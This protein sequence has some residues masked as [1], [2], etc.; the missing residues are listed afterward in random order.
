VTDAALRL[1]PAEHASVRLLDV[2]GLELLAGARSGVGVTHRPMTFRRGVGVIG[3]VVSSGETARIARAEVDPRFVPPADQGFTIGS[4]LATPLWSGGKVIGVL[5]VTS[6]IEGR[7]S[8]MH[9]DLIRLVANCTVPSIDRARLERLSITDDCTAAYNHRYLMPRL[10]DEMERARRHVSPLS[11]LLL[12]LDYFKQVNDSW[13]HQAGD[14]VLAVFADRARD[15]VRRQDVLVRRGGEEFV[16]I[17]P[18]TGREEAEHVAERIRRVMADEPIVLR[19]GE[20]IRQSVSIGV[21]TWDGVEQPV[22]LE[23]R[24][25]RAMYTAKE[26]GRNRV[27]TAAAPARV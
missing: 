15:Q 16:L 8:V 1:I 9:E 17:M 26:A 21:A 18:D 14:D 24:A 10:A 13:G 25:D 12:D 27:M 6:P 3:W 20:E 5:S 4:I 7:F 11:V 22:E 2:G 23:E 19:G